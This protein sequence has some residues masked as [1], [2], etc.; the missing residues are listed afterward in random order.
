L[1]V[2]PVFCSREARVPHGFSTLRDFVYC[3]WGSIPVH[4]FLLPRIFGLAPFGFS[5]P[6]P[7]PS[8]APGLASRFPTPI[9]TQAHSGHRCFRFCAPPDLVLIAILRVARTRVSVYGASQ[10]AVSI[11]TLLLSDSPSRSVSHSKAQDFVCPPVLWPIS[12]IRCVLAFCTE[13]P[14]PFLA[15]EA[16]H[17]VCSHQVLISATAC[18]FDCRVIQVLAG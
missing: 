13:S 15:A 7:F 4:R 14:V 18:Q 10:L 17:V 3:S 5:W 8:P 12:A 16:V 1:L 11:F 6:D 9:S 2:T